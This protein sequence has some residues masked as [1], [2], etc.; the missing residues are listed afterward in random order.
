[1][2][3]KDILSVCHPDWLQVDGRCIN[4]DKVGGIP[5]KLLQVPVKEITG[6]DD[7]LTVE[8]MT[9]SSPCKHLPV[10]VYRRAREAI[11]LVYSYSAVGSG[12]HIVLDD[13]NVEDEHIKWCLENSIPDIKSERE[14]NACR[15]CAELLLQI[16]LTSRKQ[17]VEGYGR[18]WW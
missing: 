4:T 17:L 5:E 11:Q 3:L 2:K 6:F 18:E 13:E 16:P 15:K 9:G 7:G 1:M 12:L 14:K 8:L 10:G